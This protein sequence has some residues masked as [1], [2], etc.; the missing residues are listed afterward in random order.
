M[1][2]RSKRVSNLA[3][4]PSNVPT[5]IISA[6]RPAALNHPSSLPKR[7]LTELAYDCPA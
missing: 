1:E 6:R 4:R 5:G 7:L 3:Y 2:H